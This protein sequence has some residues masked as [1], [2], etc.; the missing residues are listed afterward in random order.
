MSVDAENTIG[1]FAPFP[2]PG[3]NNRAR[4]KPYEMRSFLSYGTYIRF[5]LSERE[6]SKARRE[7]DFAILMYFIYN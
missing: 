6:N 3:S 5:Y 2:I 4:A 7:I 1:S